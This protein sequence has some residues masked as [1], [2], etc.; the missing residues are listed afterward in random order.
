MET[1]PRFFSEKPTLDA[2]LAAD[3]DE[4]EVKARNVIVSGIPEASKSVMPEFKADKD[5]LE[6]SLPASTENP[7]GQ[8]EFEA[9]RKLVKMEH[10]EL[11]KMEHEEQIAKGWIMVKTLKEQNSLVES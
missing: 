4:T 5:H 8:K 3:D 7:F 2:L 11:V 10:E 9:I 1:S 6:S